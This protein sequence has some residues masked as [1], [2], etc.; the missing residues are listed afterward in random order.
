MLACT[1]QAVLGNTK[2]G[3][4]VAHTERERERESNNNNNYNN[5]S[6]V[7]VVYSTFYRTNHD[8]RRRL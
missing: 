4:E 6:G 1:K 2:S 7:E 3:V 5:S 8:D